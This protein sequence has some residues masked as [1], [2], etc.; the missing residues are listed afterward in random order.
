MDE[1]AFEKVP[2]EVSLRAVLKAAPACWKTML[3]ITDQ[4]RT[5]DKSETRIGFQQV[6]LGVERTWQ[7]N[8]III[9]KDQ[10]L[11]RTYLDSRV[12]RPS[13]LHV[14][15]EA[16][17]AYATNRPADFSCLVCRAVI[18]DDYLRFSARVFGTV[19][20]LRQHSSPVISGDN[21]ANSCHSDKCFDKRTAIY[22]VHQSRRSNGISLEPA[23]EMAGINWAKVVRLGKSNQ[24]QGY[25]LSQHH[26][27]KLA[28]G[29]LRP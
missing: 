28:A 20:S 17:V 3:W 13:L 15:V 18:D 22:S 6:D 9:K 1:G 25:Y 14:W 21:D 11:S 7:A 4:D 16:D 23:C 19:N 26:I 10:K 2:E 29:R 24:A 27:L 5:I 12:A 8:V